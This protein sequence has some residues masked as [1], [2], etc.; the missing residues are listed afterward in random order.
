[1]ILTFQLNS[2]E[3]EED[4]PPVVHSIHIVIVVHVGFDGIDEARVKLLRLVKDEQSLG[5]AQHHVSD[6]L[7][8]LALEAAR[9]FAMHFKSH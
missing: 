9:R 5:A 3:E 2:P 7:P 1:M 8:Q 6:G 4:G